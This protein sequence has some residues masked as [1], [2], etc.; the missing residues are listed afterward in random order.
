MIAFGYHPSHSYIS[1]DRYCRL[2]ILDNPQK[3]YYPTLIIVNC[4]FEIVHLFF[5]FLTKN[6][7]GLLTW[8]TILCFDQQITT[9]DELFDVH[10]VHKDKFNKDGSNYNIKGR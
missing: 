4:Q 10:K 6:F 3:T 1:E 7:S 9:I 8:I 2:N 5:W